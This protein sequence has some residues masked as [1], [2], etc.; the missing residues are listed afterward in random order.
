MVD[1]SELRRIMDRKMES[2]LS[3]RLAE[4]HEAEDIIDVSDGDFRQRIL[5]AD[6][7]AL[8]D[9]WASWCS[10]CM[11]L[12]PIIRRVATRH[13]GEMIFARMNVDKDKS[14]PASYLVMSIPTMIVFSGGGERERIVGLA[15]EEAIERIII[16]YISA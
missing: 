14:I 12:E 4:S 9:F 1:D 5:S 3:R 11:A 6:L 10:P 16:P 8:V 15:S 7:P 2:F 13:R